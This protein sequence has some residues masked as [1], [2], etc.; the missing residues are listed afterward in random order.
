MLSAR[1]SQTSKDAYYKA[2]DILYLACCKNELL[3]ARE[4]A[5]GLDDSFIGRVTY[6]LWYGNPLEF[7]S[8]YATADDIYIRILMQHSVERMRSLAVAKM[9]KVYYTVPVDWAARWLGTNEASETIAQFQRLAPDSVGSVQ[10]NVIR[11]VRRPAVAN[12]R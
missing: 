9:T 8:L 1:Y 5:A 10:D 6:S 4:K 2:L 3:A 7:F 12:K 11:L